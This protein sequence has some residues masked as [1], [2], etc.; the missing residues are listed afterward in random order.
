VVAQPGEI[1]GDRGAP[2]RLVESQGPGVVEIVA[3][4]V[5]G[6]GESGVVDMVVDDEGACWRRTDPCASVGEQLLE[7][8]STQ[9][10]VE[11]ALPYAAAIATPPV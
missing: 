8:I 10:H 4:R 11:A 6:R 1:L 9:E 3:Y 2:Q 7:A 5:R